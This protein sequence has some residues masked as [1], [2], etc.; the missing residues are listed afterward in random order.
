MNRTG[1][2]CAKL[3]INQLR[4]L[5]MCLL[6]AAV[7][8]GAGSCKLF[9]RKS[10]KKGDLI[11]QPQAGVID[12]DMAD[13]PMDDAF[14]HRPPESDANPES[15]LKRITFE[16]DSSQLSPEAQQTLMDNMA[17]VRSHPNIN[18]LVEGHCDERGTFEYNMNLGEK[19]AGSVV[20]F[21]TRHGIDRNRLFIISYGEERPLD[22]EYGEEHWIKNRRVEFKKY[23]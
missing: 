5:T 20:D 7:A 6:I 8:A 12:A 4:R 11:A 15:A 17:W 23:E 10:A 21:M 19:R 16:Y 18:I 9:S 2:G 3:N 14:A 1:R 22:P 13:E